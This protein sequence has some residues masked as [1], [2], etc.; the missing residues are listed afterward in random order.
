MRRGTVKASCNVGVRI[1]EDL[2][3]K[4]K[5]MADEHEMS[6]SALICAVLEEAYRLRL[7]LLERRRN[8]KP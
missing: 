1:P 6:V 5:T 4:V 2:F 3:K 7:A 8:G